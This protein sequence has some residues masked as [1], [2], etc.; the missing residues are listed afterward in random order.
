MIGWIILGALTYF[1]FGQAAYCVADSPDMPKERAVAV[2]MFWPI[3]STAHFLK[4][5]VRSANI[6]IDDILEGIL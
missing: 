2:G 3:Y 4:I 6:L 1:I 5:F